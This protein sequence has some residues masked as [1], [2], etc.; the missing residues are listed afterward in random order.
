MEFLI[1]HL[2]IDELLNRNLLILP[3][4]PLVFALPFL[5]QNRSPLIG[6]FVVQ[7]EFFGYQNLINRLYIEPYFSSHP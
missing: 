4:F 6:K 7:V 3:L 1:I 2:N 5:L